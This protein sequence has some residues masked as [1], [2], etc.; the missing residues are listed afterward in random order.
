MCVCVHMY[1]CLCVYQI[2]NVVTINWEFSLPQL[3]YSY[4]IIYGLFDHCRMIGGWNLLFT[5]ILC[6]LLPCHGVN[7]GVRFSFPINTLL[8]CHMP[9]PRNGP[10]ASVPEPRFRVPLQP[11]ETGSVWQPVKSQYVTTHLTMIEIKKPYCE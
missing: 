4:L 10:L 6:L 1:Y 8:T 5:S 3:T 7:N 9:D 2:E 11:A